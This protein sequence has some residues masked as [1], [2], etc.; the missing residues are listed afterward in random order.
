MYEII[1]KE[2]LHQEKEDQ[3]RMTVHFE[4]AVKEELDHPER[5]LQ[6][7]RKKNYHPEEILRLSLKDTPVRVSSE[8]SIRK[9]TLCQIPYYHTHDFYELVYVYRGKGG[10]YLAGEK[11]PLQMGP[12]DMC[13]LTPGKIH[14][15][16]PSGNKDIV[17]KLILPRT[18]V[19]QLSS[20]CRRD[21]DLR[22]LLLLLLIGLGRAKMERQSRSFIYTVAD[23]IQ[24]HICSAE[25]DDLAARMG[26]SS[27]DG[28]FRKLYPISQLDAA[29]WSGFDD[30]TE[31]PH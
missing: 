29:L 22:S 1:Q 20:E 25:L 7:L 19:K 17:L 6:L 11:E 4:R 5:Y 3:A 16:M 8:I 26:Y 15:M 12:G 2:F 30:N 9:H 10:Q 14:A 24:S 31:L 23:Y 13:L 21:S 18:L 27:R 28:I